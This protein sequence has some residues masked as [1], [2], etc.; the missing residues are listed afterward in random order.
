MA[1]ALAVNS[2]F[3]GAAAAGIGIGN[4]SCGLAST[5]GIDWPSGSGVFAAM[6]GNDLTTDAEVV[7]ITRSAGTLTL[8]TGSFT[9]AHA[10]GDPIVYLC[11][12]NDLNNFARLDAVST[13]TA[14]PI[15]P[16]G[17]TSSVSPRNPSNSNTGPYWPTATTFAAAAGGNQIW[18]I[19]SVAMTV[20][21][22]MSVLGCFQLQGVN[23]GA[24][25]NLSLTTTPGI[26]DISQAT[27]T[28]NLPQRAWTHIPAMYYIRDTYGYLTGGGSLTLNAYDDSFGL[29][30]DV[31][32]KHPAFGVWSDT[33]GGAGLGPGGAAVT[34]TTQWQH[35]LLWG[36]R[37]DTGSGAFGGWNTAPINPIGY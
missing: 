3:L 15:L 12:A 23:I 19:S 1:R 37:I 24:T 28:I 21:R 34:L 10:L 33:G 13:F 17:S 25:L 20:Q 9:K 30:N 16:L 7:Q 29:F 18:S 35:W 14:A 11:D 6:V 27:S 4:T 36:S 5:V 26:L 22:A 8:A 31:N 2:T 32:G